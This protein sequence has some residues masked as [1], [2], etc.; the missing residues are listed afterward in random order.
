MPFEKYG[1]LGSTWGN[2]AW[3]NFRNIRAGAVNTAELIM[4]GAGSI[5]RSSNF[6]DSTTGWQIKGD[7]SA[8]FFGLVSVGGDIES[9]NWDGTSPADLSSGPDAG[10]T[11][12]F[13]LDS[14]AVRLS[15][16]ASLP[17]VGR[18]ET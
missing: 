18:L 14:S 15:S 11:V 10:A 9:A 4:V 7:G 13:Y 2:P 17:K 1:D 5:L 6:D 3:V 12:G 16:R 8:K